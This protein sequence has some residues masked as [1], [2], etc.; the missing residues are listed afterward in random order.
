LLKDGAVVKW[1][2]KLF[3]AA[4]FCILCKAGSTVRGNMHV[5]QIFM[6]CKKS[7]AVPKNLLSNF[8]FYDFNV[9][10]LP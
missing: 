4:S 5:Q 6:Q 9:K 3:L 10:L 8:C 1:A 2:Q 7:K